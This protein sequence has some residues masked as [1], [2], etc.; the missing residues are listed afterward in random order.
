M[1]YLVSIFLGNECLME[2]GEMSE[3]GLRELLKHMSSLRNDGRSIF[4][5]ELKLNG[6][7]IHKPDPDKQRQYAFAVVTKR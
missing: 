4:I 2:R 7:A 3:N 6:S 5:H 1:D